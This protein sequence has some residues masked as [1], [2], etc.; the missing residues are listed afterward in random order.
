MFEPTFSSLQ[1]DPNDSPFPS[2]E[3]RNLRFEKNV[4]YLENEDGDLRPSDD[5]ILLYK[6][7]LLYHVR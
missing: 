3:F 6:A 4:A 1:L 7:Q 2:I 5:G